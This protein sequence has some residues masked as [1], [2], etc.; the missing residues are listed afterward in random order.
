[1]GERLGEGPLLWHVGIGR[2]TPLG[3]RDAGLSSASGPCFFL[4]AGAS[5]LFAWCMLLQTARWRIAKRAGFVGLRSGGMW[6]GW[7]AAAVAGLFEA[8]V[9][10]VRYVPRKEE[11]MAFGSAALGLSLLWVIWRAGLAIFQPKES[12]LGGV[13]ACR[14]LV[15]MFTAA[16]ALCLLLMIP[17]RGE[18]KKW[19]AQDRM[20][21]P[22]PA[23]SLLQEMEARGLEDL[24]GKLRE[25][26]E[27]P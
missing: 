15:P 11:F 24:R 23:G 16:A 8:A 10:I 20:G 17:L 12:A 18:E 22:D 6:V 5:L 9:G 2:F 1:M 14:L 4:Q 7:T 25:E 19:V 13:I 26:W 27:R 3:W 21:G